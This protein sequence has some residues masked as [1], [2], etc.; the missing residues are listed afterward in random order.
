[1]AKKL[2]KKQ[3]SDAGRA[4]GALGA[5]KGGKARAAKLTPRKRSQIARLGG[6]ASAAARKASEPTVTTEAAS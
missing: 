3:S 4:L 1:M 6:R 5:S 2:T